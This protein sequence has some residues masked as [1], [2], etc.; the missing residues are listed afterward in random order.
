[1]TNPEWLKISGTNFAKLWKL[2][3]QNLFVDKFSN[4]GI[5]LSLAESQNVPLRIRRA[6]SP[7]ALYSNS[8]LLFLN[9]TLLNSDNALLALNWWYF[10]LKIKSVL[11]LY[12]FYW[13]KMYAL[14]ALRGHGWTDQFHIWEITDFD[15]GA[16]KFVNGGGGA[17]IKITKLREMVW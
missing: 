12:K 14:L 5:T 9:A 8:A 16:C 15:L 7:Y 6:L 3:K 11:L 13:P 1:M 2:P 10:L 4:N 17:V